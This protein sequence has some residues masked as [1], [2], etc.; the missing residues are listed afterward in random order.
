MTQQ[1]QLKADMEDVLRRQREKNPQA[2]AA[3]LANIKKVLTAK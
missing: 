2:T 3:L 1:E